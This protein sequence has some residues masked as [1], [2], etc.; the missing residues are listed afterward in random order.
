MPSTV[1]LCIICK[2]EE[3]NLPNLLA[4]V[5][6]CFDQIHIADTGSTDGTVE[7]LKSRPDVTLHHFDWV[8]DFSAARN[9]IFSKSTADYSMWLDCDDV[10]NGREAFIEWKKTLLDTANYWLAAYHY[11]SDVNGRP[12]CSFARER[13]IKTNM[14]FEW[15][16][17]I[18]EGIAPTPK[19]GKVSVAYASSWSVKHVRTEEDIKVDRNRNLRIFE[20]NKGKMNDR[21]EYYYGKEL[22]EAQQA[23]EA[24]QQLT[25]SMDL[26]GLEFHDRVLCVQYACMAAMNCNQ[27]D[28]AIELAHKGLRLAPQRAEFYVIIADS[29]LKLN[30]F[31][32]AIPYYVA[33]S[34]CPN[35]TPDNA[36]FQQPLFTDAKVYAHYPRNQLARVMFHKGKINEAKK[37]LE[38]ALLLGPDPETGILYSEIL[39]VEKQITIPKKGSVPVADEYVITCPHKSMYLW[40]EKIIK[41]RG[42]GGSE[43]AAIRMARELHKQ[44]G[45]KV[46]IFMDRPDELEVDGVFYL[47]HNRT[48]E[49]F[50]SCEPKAHIAWRHNV[51][52]TNA[53][54]YL[55]CHDLGVPEIDNVG[56]YDKVLALSEFHKSYLMHTFR[57]PEEKIQVTR[58][59]IDLDRFKDVNLSMKSK[60]KI[61]YSSSPDRGL[62]SAIAVVKKARQM[63]GIDFE[64]HAFYGLDNMV[65]LGLHNEVARFKKL[66]NDNPWV[67]FHGNVKQDELIKHIES[68][69]VWLY[70]T[71]FLETFCITALEMLACQVRPLV[72]AYGALPYTLKDLPATI[73]DSDCVTDEQIEMW[74]QK[75]IV[76]S[77]F[78]Q[79]KVDMTPYTWES[80]AKEWLTWLPK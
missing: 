33:A 32:D 73:L 18:H 72:R 40:D 13:V 59:G 52:V 19:I 45:K 78:E 27:F 28:K 36:T 56:V 48:R 39:N 41:E 61:V 24:Y 1:A 5:E 29:Y 2:N 38:E 74:A 35:P 21:L 14:G 8:D 26:A 57:V 62:D 43:T 50:C 69:W 60:N 71:N 7:Y 25:K 17:F 67:K 15:S 9:F 11:A 64:L 44:T 66:I 6:G 58:N 49:Y 30:R 63:S 79:P 10:L 75:L 16:H 54:T 76:A 68:A 3:K 20:K 4:S 34:N 12:V 51:K 70:P 37:Y 22:F 55:W 65:K 80:V 42:V 53:P 47:P 31:D 46:R 77:A 23:L